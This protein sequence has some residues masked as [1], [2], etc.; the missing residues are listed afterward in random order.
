MMTESAISLP[1]SHPHEQTARCDAETPTI[2]ARPGCCTHMLLIGK[3]EFGDRLRSGWV[4]ACIMVWLGAIGLTSFLGLLQIGQ[5]GIQGYERTVMSLL[6]LIQYLVPLLGLL[7]GHDLIAS[8]NEERTFRLILATGV[9]RTRLLLGKFLGGVLTLACPLIAGFTIAGV[10]IGFTARDESI[11]PFI[12]LALSGLLLGIVFVGMGL[13]ISTFCR[14]R[15]QALVIALLAWCFFV[16]VFDLV[17]LGLIVSTQSRAA[18]REIELICD[19][20]HVNAA[21]DLHSGFDAVTTPLSEH[22][23]PSFHSRA[24]SWLTLNPV[25]LFR[26]VNLAQATGVYLP[27]LWTFASFAAWLALILTASLW[28]FRRTDL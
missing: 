2:V 21:A 11:E 15:V 20:L 25:D 17:A 5:I 8:E 27:I 10:V 7:L 14:T 16:F 24:L 1:T 18:A 26:T 13:V 3:K 4:I 19:A 12:R 22:S 28:R 9:T 6:N 23:P